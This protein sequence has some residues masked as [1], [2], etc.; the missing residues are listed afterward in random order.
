MLNMVLLADY[1][2]IS[3]SINLACSL[4]NLSFLMYY[5]PYLSR[6]TNF[7]SIWTEGGIFLMFSLCATFEYG[8]DSETSR[9]VMWTGVGLIGLIMFV[10]IVEIVYV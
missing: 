3:L 2:W 6:L 8:Y 5:S 1:V 7:V 9:T 4:I 10:N